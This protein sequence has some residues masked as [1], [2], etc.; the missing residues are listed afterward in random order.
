MQAYDIIPYADSTGIPIDRADRAHRLINVTEMFK[1]S[2]APEHKKPYQWFNQEQTQE[3]VAE[4]AKVS[5]APSITENRKSEFLKVS[6]APSIEEVSKSPERTSNT[7][8]RKSEIAKSA[9]TAS[10]TET[11]K[12]GT[13]GGGSTWYCEELALA[14]AMYLSPRLHLACLRFILGSQRQPQQPAPADHQAELEQRVAALEQVQ[15]QRIAVLEQQLEQARHQPEPDTITITFSMAGRY[16]LAVMRDL[17]GVVTPKQLFTELK[18]RGQDVSYLKI[19]TWLH[20][21]AK[22]GVLKRRARGRYELRND[23]ENGDPH[24]D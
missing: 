21:S 17:G 13:G 9:E 19:L 6:E 12:G 2:G 22:R 11:R 23:N 10:I 1:A 14:Y 16:R 5:E 3:L 7:E 24:A 8:T 15:R 20:Q 4:I 18:R